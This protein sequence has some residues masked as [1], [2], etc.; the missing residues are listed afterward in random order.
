MLS[1]DPIFQC[2]YKERVH[3]LKNQRKYDK[4]KEKTLNLVNCLKNIEFISCCVFIVSYVVIF[5]LIK[6]KKQA[7]EKHLKIKINRKNNGIKQGC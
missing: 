1:L 3:V 5:S 4:F 2:A 7:N 6:K